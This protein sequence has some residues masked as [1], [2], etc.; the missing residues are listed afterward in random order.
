MEGGDSSVA[1]I[2]LGYVG[3][4]TAALLAKAG[5]R[6]I[7]VDIDERIVSALQARRSPNLEPEIKTLVEEVLATGKLVARTE[8]EAADAFV[9]CVPTPIK[10]DR[11]PDLSFLDAAIRSVAKVAKTGNLV[12]LEST[13]PIGT[14][15]NLVAPRL[16]EE[17]LDPYE[18]IDIAYCPERVFPGNTMHE[19]INNSRIVG[20][21]TQRAATRAAKLYGKF[22]LGEVSTTSAGVAEFVKLMENTFRDV[23]IAL[24]NAFAAIAENARLDVM[25]AISLANRHPRVNIHSAGAGVGG[26]C[27]PVDPWFLIR[28]FPG[29]TALMAQARE[30]NDGQPVH[31]LDRAE[32][33]GLVRGSM[34]ALLGVAYRG[35]IGDTRESPA[36][37]LIEV[38]GRRGYRWTAH[39]PHVARWETHQGSY[40]VE[41]DV[42]AT[43]SRA[44]AVF[45]M[46]D[47]D[48]YRSLGPRDFSHMHGRLIVDGRRVLDVGKFAHSNLTILRVG[49][50][51]LGHG[52]VA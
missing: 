19:M 29:I 44:D 24:A 36:E 14:S 3:L 49:A 21:L 52:A 12:I 20:G 15:A 17:G 42:P 2:G 23:N 28:E 10:G 50:P 5:L 8:I 18:G 9:V 31:L 39:D 1:V 35:N 13:C 22:C 30:I 51:L 46:T 6:V 7:G 26:H 40:P 48:L 34:V 43:V 11:S 33:A 47:H 16:S 4:P 38:L 27:I 32:A 45:I 41:S 37:R 25:E